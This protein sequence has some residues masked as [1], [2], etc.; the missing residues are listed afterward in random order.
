MHTERVV[1]V[2]R[3]NRTHTRCWTRRAVGCWLS[4][5]T[6][7]F[8]L[9]CVAAMAAQ[10]RLKDWTVENGLPQ[11]VIRGISQTPDGY[12]WIATL[13]GLARFDGVNFTVFNKS[14]TT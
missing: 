10:F 11:N 3:L 9:N 8:L 13:D 7:L 6:W 14:K 12:I 4:C 2:R 1:L 5:L